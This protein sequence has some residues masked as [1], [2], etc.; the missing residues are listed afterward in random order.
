ML[1]IF[2]IVLDKT[3]S[4]MLIS[5]D[6]GVESI[7]LFMALWECVQYFTTGNEIYYSFVVDI[8]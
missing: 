3:S 8:N 7:A 4:P 2:F 6:E 1:L 5:W